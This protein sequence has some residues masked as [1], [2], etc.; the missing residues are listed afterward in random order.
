MF[1][2]VKK[3]GRN[4]YTIYVENLKVQFVVTENNK[5]VFVTLKIVCSLNSSQ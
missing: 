3:K 1:R 5:C 4:C 2:K